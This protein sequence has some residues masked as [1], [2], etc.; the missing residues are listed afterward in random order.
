MQD[1]LI[2]RYVLADVAKTCVVRVNFTDAQK[3]PPMYALAFSLE[4]VFWLYA[5]EIG[6][7]VLGPETETWPDPSTLSKRLRS[8]DSDVERVTV[9]ANPVVPAYR[10]DQLYLTNACVIG[11]LNSLIW[12]L[13]NGGDASHAGLILMSYETSHASMA[14]AMQVNHSL[15]AYQVHG[16][17][18][19]IDPS[20]VGDPF[21]L[22][23]VAVGEPLDPALVALTLKHSYPVKSVCLLSLSRGTLDRI[24]SNVRWAV[25]PLTD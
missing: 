18:W 24:T 22:E 17:W 7:R 21:P 10:P 3:R 19:C 16:K 11:S 8:L 14:A 2:A 1:A 13:H 5:P 4:K 6:T 15:L 12:V 25:P 23:N 9:Y 20:H